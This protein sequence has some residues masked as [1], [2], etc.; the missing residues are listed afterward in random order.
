MS[1]YGELKRRHVI[2]VGIAYLA[3]SWL[4]IQLVDTLLP[5]FGL[6]QSSARIFV[7][8]LIIGFVP[9]LVVSWIFEFTSEG[10]KRDEGATSN[11]GRDAR[12]SRRFNGT[13][14]VLLAL[15]TTYFAVDK[16]LLEPVRDS[17]EAAVAAVPH[18]VDVANAVSPGK[19]IAVLPFADMSVDGDQAYFADGISEELLNL[20][21]SIRELRVIS[22]S[23]SFSFREEQPDIPTIARLLDVSHIL[24]GSVRKS[25]NRIRIT[26]QLID[27]RTDTHLW[28][29]TYDR[30]LDDVFA[31]Q[32]EISAMVV[33]QLRLTLLG[34][35]QVVYKTNPESYA[36]Y[37]QARHI[38]S[39]RLSDSYDRAEL[40]LREALESDPTFV[41]GWAELAKIYLGQTQTG[42]RDVESGI[43]L[44]RDVVARAEDIDPDYREVITWNAW[45]AFMWDKDIAKG[46]QLF[47]RSLA[48]DPAHPDTLRLV[49]VL[50]RSL[51]RNT[52]AIEVGEFAIARDPLCLTCYRNLL[53]AYLSADRFDEMINVVTRM[54][55]LGLDSELIKV[56]AGDAYLSTGDP[57]HALDEYLSIDLNSGIAV[58]RRHRGSAIA[59]Y[60]LGRTE[61]FETALEALISLAGSDMI[62][63]S[64]YGRTDNADM[65]F[66]ILRS[67][68]PGCCNF[69]NLFLRNLR[70][71]GRWDDFI[72]EY[73]RP[74]EDLSYIEFNYTLPSNNGNGRGAEFN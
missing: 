62:L 72:E 38:W 56:L 39:H 54:R 7:L 42:M 15:A 25:G 44:A 41:P 65:A 14:I 2:R 27:A 24:E 13:I 9:A 66:E 45:I 36:L 29:E 59:Y 40:L 37:L 20:L 70:N 26:A 8:F 64:V 3:G 5:I 10:L 53:N 21:A 18:R 51:G 61:D 30:T 68:E 60:E 58:D 46:A 12:L 34:P 52:D 57:E 69:D 55:S 48:V 35:A 32:D 6:P 19:S 4:L 50:L 47:E 49:M 73:G 67:L 31:I 33:E 43:Q 74:Q 11:S 28:S 23:S 63:A 22:R 17:D 1:L 16:F 71:D